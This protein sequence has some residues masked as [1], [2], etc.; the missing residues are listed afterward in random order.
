MRSF[1]PALQLAVIIGTL[2]ASGPALGA[3][4]ESDAFYRPRCRCLPGQSCWPSDATWSSFNQTVGGRLIATYPVARECHEPFYDKATCD[5]IKQGYIWDHW[6]QLRP[7]AIQQVNWEVLDGKGCLGFNQTQPCH[8]G[9]VPVLTVNASSIADIQATVRYASEHNLRLVIKNTGHDYLGRSTAANSLS[10][11]TY[12]RQKITTT[13]SFVP[14]GAPK[15]TKGEHAVI[16]ESGALLKD[17][18]LAVHQAGRIVVGGADA[19]VGAAGG[20]CAGGGHG[21]L[22]PMHGLCVDNIL[23]V[24]VVTADGQL[25]VANAHQNQDL[26]WALRGGGAGTF[27]VAVEMVLRT[28]PALKNIHY[29]P[30]FIA[31]PDQAKLDLIASDF[32]A[33]QPELGQ[34]GFSG[35]CFVDKG[36]IFL[37]Y[38]LP[39]APLAQA[40]AG[41]RPWL[42]YA[43][44]LGNVTVTNDTIVTVPDY[45]TLFKSYMPGEGSP[46]AGVN[47]IIGSRLIPARLLR[48][49][50]KAYQVS[51]VLS[52]ISSS[53][54]A[55]LPKEIVNTPGPHGLYLIHLVAGGQV[56]AL[57]QANETSLLP[58]W[59]EALNHVVVAVA[60]QN[61]T[62][63]DQQRRI[64]RPSMDRL[65]K[66]TPG[67]GA[68]TNEADPDE[69]DWQ[70]SFWGANYPR[71][72]AIKRK[73]DPRGLFVCR[74]CVGSED[75]SDDLNCHRR[76]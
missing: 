76:R 27:G 57:G 53:V 50:E 29:V 43:R 38:Y 58:A 33:R 34:A 40:Q 64:Q 4:E 10:L 51:S 3:P 47:H 75:W 37:Q 21:P 26:F 71:L 45:Y 72:R 15:E 25:R 13:D 70:R 65:R 11:W 68:Y 17:V 16:L 52:G 1:L 31:S 18:F 36:Y 12:F 74:L 20:F 24:T 32:W 7:G 56:A 22:S 69:P 8:Q 67:S 19:T 23:Q 41:I 48:S 54:K 66:I 63:L 30:A 28:H 2:F 60:W 73:Y 14:E 35:Y 6:R 42:D 62:P 46:K 49:K 39:N 59:R 5:D 61:H 44:S 9:N 55:T